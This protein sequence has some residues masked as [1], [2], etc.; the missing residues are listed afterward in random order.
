V[1]CFLCGTDWILKYYVQKFRLQRAKYVLF[2]ISKCRR[3]CLYFAAPFSRRSLNSRLI[4]YIW[5]AITLTRNSMK[6][7]SVSWILLHCNAASIH[8]LGFRLASFHHIFQ[9]KSYM[10]I[11]S[12]IYIECVACRDQLFNLGSEVNTEEHRAH[13]TQITWRHSVTNHSMPYVRIQNHSLV[14][15]SSYSCFDVIQ[16]TDC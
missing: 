9:T 10:H 6:R 13:I 12:N 15:M 7:H 16:L 14:E 5:V 11:L 2:C 1:L 3:T 4:L 8:N